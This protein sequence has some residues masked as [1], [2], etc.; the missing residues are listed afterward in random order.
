MIRTALLASAAVFALGTAAQAADPILPAP[1]PVAPAP[2]MTH[3]WSG[4]YAGINAGFGSGGAYDDGDLLDFGGEDI[5]D[6]SG[7]I[8]GVQVGANFQADMFVLGVEG[9]IQLSTMSQTVE[10]GGDDYIA[11]LDYFGTVR[12]RAGVA[13]DNVMPYLTGGLAYGGVTVDTSDLDP[14]Y[15]D[16][17]THWGWTIGGGVEVAMDQNVSFKAEYLYTDLGEEEFQPDEGGPSSSPFDA[18]LQFHTIRAGVN[19]H[20]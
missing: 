12:A 1:T 15:V 11:S 14:D 20:F 6:I 8:G 18:G 17:N 4:F 2:A 10:L 3:D 9:D 5:D 13:I 19:F 16:S 7:F